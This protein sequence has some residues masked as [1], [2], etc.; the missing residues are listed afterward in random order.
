M[1]NNPLYATLKWCGQ[2]RVSQEW[3]T[4]ILLEVRRPLDRLTIYSL[5]RL[6]RYYESRSAV[7]ERR[8]ATI[9]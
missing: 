6:R 1:A 8:K 2:P 9:G 7:S 3:T 4:N 5:N